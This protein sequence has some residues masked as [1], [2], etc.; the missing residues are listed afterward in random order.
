MANEG[1]ISAADWDREETV[2]I[3]RQ[4]YAEG[5]LDPAELDDRADAAFSART[6]SELR[7]LIADIP[8]RHAVAPLP[9][10]QPGQPETSRAPWRAFGHWPWT[11]P[12]MLL[13]ALVCVVIGAATRNAAVIA[14]AV[15]AGFAAA[16]SGR[17]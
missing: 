3:L 2:E 7:G 17:G 6:I 5:R 12:L 14:L 16:V 10:A 11:G 1:W 8:H 9:L 4:A 13:A 15:P